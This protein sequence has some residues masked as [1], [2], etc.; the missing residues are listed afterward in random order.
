MSM[1]PYPLVETTI[2]EVATGRTAVDNTPCHIAAGDDVPFIWAEGDF[3]CDCNRRL[4]FHRAQGVE[5]DDDDTPCGDGRYLVRC[6]IDGR[7]V[8]DEISKP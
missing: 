8:Y 1:E 3:S 5:L 6:A 7:V 4:L 2:L